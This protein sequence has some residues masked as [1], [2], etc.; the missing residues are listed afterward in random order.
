MTIS[1]SAFIADFQAGAAAPLIL[2]QSVEWGMTPDD[3]NH[4]NNLNVLLV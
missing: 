2:T 4:A 3:V 1:L